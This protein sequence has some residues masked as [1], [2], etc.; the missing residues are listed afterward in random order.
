MREL[1]KPPVVPVV[2]EHPAV[3]EPA[4]RELPEFRG[5]EVSTPEPVP[6]ERDDE[7]EWADLVRR[8]RELAF[9][10]ERVRRVVGDR[11]HGLIGLSRRDDKERESRT[12]VLVAYGYEDG[13][14]YEVLLGPEDDLAVRDVVA[15]DEHPAPSDEEVDLA[16]RIARADERVG[17]HLR[18]DFDAHA[19]L[20]SDVADGD[21][22]FGRRRF[23]VVFG[24]PDE[25]L[26]RVNAV[27][28]LMSEEV[29]TLFCRAGGKR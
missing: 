6:I 16:I 8:A 20:V 19:L 10:D 27:V 29:V 11:R 17:H 4:L 9:D 25:R 5:I 26:P 2:G 3:I 21:E 24:Y 28:D 12:L 18:D 22:H 1:P 7:R 23:S 13:R 15:I 14:G